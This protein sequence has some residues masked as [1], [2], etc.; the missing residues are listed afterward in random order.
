MITAASL[1][2]LDVC[3]CVCVCVCDLY[4]AHCSLVATHR[5]SGEGNAIGCVRPSLCFHAIFLIPLTSDLDSL[6][7]WVTITTRRGLTVEVILKGVK[8]Q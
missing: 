8:R 6:R 4:D 3:V 7:A 2:Q 5:V 1:H